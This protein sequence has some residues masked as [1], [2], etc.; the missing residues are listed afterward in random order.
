MTTA[1]PGTLLRHIQ[2]LATG[3]RVQQRTDRQLLDDFAA[4]RDESAFAA[5]VARHGPMVLRVCRRVLGHEQD[6]EDAFQATFL[7]LARNTASIRKRGALA[8]WLH[9][10]AYRTA[11]KA[12]RGAA[13]RRNH[14]ARRRA[15][16]PEAV[17]SPRW[18]EVQAVLDEEIRALPEPF[19]AAFTLCVLEGKSGPQAAAELGCKEG[20]VSSR[21]TRAR[22]RLRQQLA[23]R[24]IQL[25]ALL[26][27]LSVAESAGRA[28]L[29][30]T[31]AQATVGFGLLVAAGEPAAGVI[32]PHIAALAAGVTRAMFLTKAKIATA[33]LFALGFIVAGA[34]ALTRQALSTPLEEAKPQAD[35]KRPAEG[36]SQT[37]GEKDGLVDVRGRVLDPEGRPVSGAKLLVVCASTKKVPEKVW[38]TSATDGG[39]HFTIAPGVLDDAWSRK[40]WEYTYVVA[41]A[42]HYG[43]GVAPLGKPGAA[44]L[45]L[46]LV[47]DDVPIRGRVLD[48]QGK[49]VAGATVRIDD[50][51]YVHSKGD[52]RSWLEALKAGK[53]NPN[54]LEEN[55]FTALSSQA[56]ARLFPAV[57]TGADGRFQIKGI[58]RE[59]IA[60]LRVEGPTI[61]T[62]VVM[63]MTRVAE[64]IQV[65][66]PAGP[67]VTYHGATFDLL[68]IPTKPVVG[69]VRDK[70]TGRP[71]AGVTVRSHRVAGAFDLNGLV[72]TATDREGRYRL[73]GLPKGPGNALIAEAYGHMPQ[74]GDLPYLAAIREVGDTPGLE[75]VT[76]DVALK[77]GVWVKGRVIDKA[78]GKPVRGGF[79]YFCF[80]DNPGAT[81]LPLLGRIPADWTQKDGSFRIVALP[82]RGL[83][84]VRADRD[85]YRMGVGADRIKG[86][87]EGVILE[88]YPYRLYPGNFHQIVEV[89]PR[90]GDESIACDVV[91]DPGRT[92]KGTVLGPDGKPLA[93]AR[94]A[95][96]RPLGYWEAQ[97][98]KEAEFTLRGLSPG[99]RRRLQMVHEGKKLA[100]WLEVRG[101][102]KGP[103]HVRLEPWGSVT[104]RLVTP[105][106]VPMTNVS[107]GLGSLP[108]VQAGKDGKFRIEG[109]APGLKYNLRVTKESYLLESS[110]KGIEN[111]TTRP[112][113]T[114]DLG[115]VEVKPME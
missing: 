81:E 10:V 39:F 90:P 83:V 1:R 35:A 49:P 52:L 14:E 110:G 48:L 115:D 86:P 94:V 16:T 3:P 75:P 89:S 11:M 18:D 74:A 47:Q 45:T 51:L 103:V 13:R 40:P 70:D 56:L 17:P 80:P 31:L 20:T 78:T 92:L 101:D 66:E 73:V 19:R 76:A 82:G 77:R 36:K 85:E 7:V 12:K 68:A 41:A 25:S 61:A 106:G 100:G 9:G 58:G 96:L 37:A 38:A 4:H 114:K 44:D 30:A 109:L 93:G 84:A 60:T 111:L 95:G 2:K 46:R 43:F 71:L 102:E 34:S 6:A 63:A 53:Q 69:V 59:R 5:L 57:M 28:A 91:L 97:P 22:E 104:G 42:K 33:V 24:G 64:R 79:D 65:T 23:R 50:H 72:R 27:G 99:E 87:R 98:L 32:P 29:P 62:Q 67:G 88:T 26:A 105:D 107:I 112:G 54:N 8:D 15:L 55:D 21:L 108:S 113:E